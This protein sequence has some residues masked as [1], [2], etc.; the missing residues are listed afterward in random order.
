MLPKRFMLILMVLLNSFFASAQGY[1]ALHGSAYT[2]STEVFN[3]PASSLNSAYKW[4]FSLFSLQLKMST[5]SNFLDKAGLRF[6]QGVNSHFIHANIDFSLLNFLYKI[7]NNKAFNFNI[8][9]RT[10][11][12]FKTSPLNINDTINSIHSFLITNRNTPFI[13]GFVTHAGWLEGD[14]NYSQVLLENSY[15]KLTGGVT[16]QIMKGISGAYLRIN[17]LSFL[18]SINAIDTSY[19]FTNGSGA[20]GYSA[21]YDAG[22]V[23]GLGDL[24]N[25]STTALGL[26]LGVEYMLYNNENGASNNNLNYNWKMGAS[27]MDIGAN[28][29][30]RGFN[31]VNLVQPVANVPD[32]VVDNKLSVAADLQG[33]KDSLSTL[34]NASTPVTGKFSISLPT[35]MIFNVDKNLGNHFYVNADVSLNFFS[36]ATIPKLHTRELNLITL[37]P[38]WETIGLGAYLPVQYN[39]Q[40]QFWVGAAI[41]VGPLV[42]GVHNLGILK[43]DPTVNGGGYLLLSLHPFNKSRVDMDCPK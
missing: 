40:G 25:K 16:L 37:T 15:S 2:G 38:R 14:L 39:T 4:D 27:I 1:Q 13:D 12:H 11:N 9:A 29:F 33:L 35:R 5:N 7:D 10:Y 28:Y 34:F 21:N 8:R 19:T 36:T 30:T 22:N 3:N 18:E 24:I 23:K 43:K 31:S 42:I 32:N 20:F 6:Q 41:K 26:S 17:K